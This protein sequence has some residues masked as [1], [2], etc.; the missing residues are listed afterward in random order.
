MEAVANKLYGLTLSEHTI[1]WDLFILQ[2]LRSKRFKR[3][4]TA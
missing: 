4:T 1:H 3:T 2:P